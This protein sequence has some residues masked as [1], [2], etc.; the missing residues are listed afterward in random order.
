MMNEFEINGEFSR[1]FKSLD[2]SLLK[3]ALPA[4]FLQKKSQC[5]IP[6]MKKNNNEHSITK[7]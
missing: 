5:Q 3:S 6:R 7:L 4:I 1:D 2:L